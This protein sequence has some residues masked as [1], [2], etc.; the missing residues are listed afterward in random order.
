[1]PLQP[2][3]KKQSQEVDITTNLSRSLG[4]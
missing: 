1:M 3:V 2:K 4:Q